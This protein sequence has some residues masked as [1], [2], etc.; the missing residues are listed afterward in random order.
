MTLD[1]KCEPLLCDEGP[2]QLCKR[3]LAQK[4][5][6]ADDQCAE[7]N[8]GYALGENL[9]CTKFTCAVGEGSACKTCQ[10]QPTKDNQCGE[11]NPG[12]EL[13][14]DGSCRPFTCA[15]GNGTVCKECHDLPLRTADGQCTACNVGF[16]LVDD[17]CM[18]SPC[19]AGEACEVCGSGAECEK[20]SP[21]YALTASFACRPHVCHTGGGR[22]KAMCEARLKVSH[23]VEPCV[24]RVCDRV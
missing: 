8:E 10:E 12:H 24:R 11:C 13:L 3:C 7:C 21:G 2:G 19:R 15:R 1:Q 4:L 22:P 9:A 14:S 6:T 17:L 20:C 5:R 23:E 18:P 16:S